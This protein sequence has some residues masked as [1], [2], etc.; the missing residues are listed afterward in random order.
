MNA[1]QIIALLGLTPL[2]PEGGYFRQ[3]YKSP[4]MLPGNILPSRYAGNERSTATAIYFLLTRDT[5][6]L[7][8]RLNS[9]EI[10]HFYLGDPVQL[11]TLYPDGHE[12]IIILGNDIDHGHTLQ[13]VIPQGV[14]QGSSLVG[15]G[16]YALLGTTVAPGFEIDDF[17]LASREILHNLYP[18]LLHAII[19]QLTLS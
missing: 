3:T 19:D 18:Q 1:E 9:D 17:E 8:H 2:D 12:E 16:E 5:R 14:W 11:V 6:S 10:Y 4:N 15:D 7:L 13:T